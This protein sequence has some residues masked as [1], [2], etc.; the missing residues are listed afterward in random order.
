M[1]KLGMKYEGCQDAVD[2][3]KIISNNT[4]QGLIDDL[5]DIASNLNNLA[6]KPDT[7][8]L[9]NC[10]SNAKDYK[11]KL[12]IFTPKLEKFISDIYTF[13]NTFH[14][15]FVHLDG[16]NYENYQKN[17]IDIEITDEYIESLISDDRYSISER[18]NILLTL[19]SDEYDNNSAF[20]GIVDKIRDFVLDP[21]NLTNLKYCFNGVS[22]KIVKKGTNTYIDLDLKKFNGR[23]TEEIAKYFYED[24]GI[25][26]EKEYDI[27]LKH[28]NKNQYKKLT[29]YINRL[30]NGEAKIISPK[31]KY[32]QRLIGGNFDDLSSAIKT[33]NSSAGM[34]FIDSALD[35]VLGEA[36]Y[37]GTGIKKLYNGGIDGVVKGI[38]KSS[39]LEFTGKAVGVVD[40]ATTIYDNVK[41]NMY[42]ENGEFDF[43]AENV[44]KTTVDTGIDLGVSAAGAALGTAALP[45][46]SAVTT[47]FLTSIGLGA[48][49]GSVV[50][51]V[52]TVVGIG[53]AVTVNVL[54]NI[55]YGDPPASA[56]DRAKNWANSGIEKLFN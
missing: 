42:D 32:A 41:D 34:K 54:S 5:N 39:V 14:E 35:D 49:A 3:L 48:T 56:I 51:V 47:T 24:L 31:S 9:T 26:S 11:D 46:A 18:L 17:I 52:G 55:E 40:K 23:S 25:L 16:T 8:K 15:N 44:T 2:K 38:S 36:K 6:N 27:I 28:S 45:V 10:I 33:V 29:N 53:I 4:Y 37:I 19:F 1:S 50:P 30:M 21:A 12:L 22:Y 20:S 43:T 13:D 7:S